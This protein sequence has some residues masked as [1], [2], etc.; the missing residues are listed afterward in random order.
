MLFAQMLQYTAPQQETSGGNYLP[1][2]SLAAVD[3]TRRGMTISYILIMTRGLMSNTDRL[4]CQE[5]HP[6]LRFLEQST[7]KFNHL[8]SH[9]Y[10]PG[11]LNLFLDMIATVLFSSSTSHISNLRE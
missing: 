1:S 3:F 8:S 7:T 10:S 4:P 5:H 9:T 2:F 6:Q 11:A